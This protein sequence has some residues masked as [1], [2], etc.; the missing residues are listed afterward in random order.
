MLAYIVVALLHPRLIFRP[1]HPLSL[2]RA[3]GITA[4]IPATQ[5]RSEVCASKYELKGCFANQRT[6][7]NGYC[8]PTSTRL[9]K[10]VTSTPRTERFEAHTLNALAYF[11]RSQHAFGRIPSGGC[12]VVPRQCIANSV[13]VGRPGVPP[14]PRVT[15]QHSPDI[16]ARLPGC[17]QYIPAFPQKQRSSR[18]TS[19]LSTTRSIAPHPPEFHAAILQ[20]AHHVSVAAD[21]NM[22]SCE[23]RDSRVSRQT[24]AKNTKTYE[25][26]NAAIMGISLRTNVVHRTASADT[27]HRNATANAGYIKASYKS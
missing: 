11:A 21:K 13:F 16:A 12:I 8:L 9:S 1:A 25:L 4:P 6:G 23:N 24:A 10:G 22:P 26:T 15:H 17:M 2:A 7:I 27:W 14:Y 20:R 5:H 3:S 19:G 18:M